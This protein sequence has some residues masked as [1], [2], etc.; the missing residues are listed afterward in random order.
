MESKGLYL[1]FPA[2]KRPTTADVRSAI[3][4]LD[5]VAISH[6]P[7]AV[8]SSDVDDCNWLEVVIDG[9]TFDIVGLAPGHAVSLS[10]AVQRANA[11]SFGEAEAIAIEP[12]PHLAGGTYI[13]PVLRGLLTLGARLGAELT[14][15]LAVGWQPSLSTIPTAQLLELA[16]NWASGGAFPSEF[17]IRFDARSDGALQSHGLSVFTGQELSLAPDIAESEDLA[18]RLGSRLANQLVLLGRIEAA[19]DITGPDGSML[20]LEPSTGDVPLVQVLR[21]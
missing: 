11:A 10:G 7:G 13:L 14:D 20:R 4:L 6:D 15:V 1:L 9:L 21:R 12:G 5:G 3:A 19:E 17:L 18:I 8:P 2:G 16:G